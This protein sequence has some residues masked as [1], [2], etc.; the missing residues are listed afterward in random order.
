MNEKEKLSK[1]QET[2]YN[3]VKMEATLLSQQYLARMKHLISVR[4]GHWEKFNDTGRKLWLRSVKATFQSF[5]FSADPSDEMRRE[6]A[7]L[8]MRAPKEY[9]QDLGVHYTE[10]DHPDGV[11]R[12]I[13]NPAEDSRLQEA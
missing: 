10:I 9:Q 13:T 5:F 2:R 4:E 8:I 7:G 12:Y 6:F 3:C 11:F 1:I